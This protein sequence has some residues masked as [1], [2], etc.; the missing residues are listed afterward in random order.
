MKK[1]FFLF[2][3][4]FSI[5]NVCYSKIENNIILKVENEIVTTYEVKNKILSTLILSN[6]EINQDNIDTLKNQVLEILIQN[7][8][9][10]IELSKYNINLESSN[11][12]YLN[13]VSENDIIGLK[14]NFPITTLTMNYF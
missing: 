11:V 7:K 6:K 8:L 14:K 12:I 10:K 13:T 9:K 4:T 1:Q 2:F 5:F 3:L